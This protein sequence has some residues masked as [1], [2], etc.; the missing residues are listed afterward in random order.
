MEV[1][2]LEDFQSFLT[3]ETIFSDFLFAFLHITLLLKRVCSKQIRGLVKVCG[4]GIVLDLF[5]H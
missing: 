2:L 5:Y 4:L 1:V 3:R